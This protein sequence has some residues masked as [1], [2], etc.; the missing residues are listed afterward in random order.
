MVVSAALPK[1]IRLADHG[2][3]NTKFGIV[4]RVLEIAFQNQP[5][6]AEHGTRNRTCADQFRVLENIYLRQWFTAEHGT[7]IF[8]PNGKVP[9][10]KAGCAPIPGPVWWDDG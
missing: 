9:P 6:T 4:F 8:L 1:E 10:A 3:R 2:T 7:R 5:L